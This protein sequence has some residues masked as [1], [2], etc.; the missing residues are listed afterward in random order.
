MSNPKTRLTI[1][2]VCFL[3]AGLLSLSFY[4]SGRPVH[5]VLYAQ[6]IPLSL[7]G[8]EGMD[9]PMDERTLQILETRDVLFRVYN[10]KEDLPVYLCV[11]F[12]AN[13][14]RAIHPPE[15]CY[16]GGGWEIGEKSFVNSE[17]FIEKPKFEATKIRIAKNYTKQLVYYW[18]K[19]G[20]EFT[21]SVFSHQISM[22]LNQ[23]LF[24]DVAGA[25][26]R[27]STE[28]K[29]EEVDAAS[30]RLNQFAHQV[31]PLILEHLP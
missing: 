14:R 27:L 1:L 5:G 4:F 9:I 20:D 21:S 10:R 24:R 2:M 16:T 12:S 11:V 28:I 8:W 13:N 30:K 3:G 29:G 18:Y 31:T 6:N 25:M 17:L 26:I 22:A 7:D 19:A 23:I 15:V